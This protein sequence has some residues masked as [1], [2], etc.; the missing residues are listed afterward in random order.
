[1][2]NNYKKIVLLKGLEVINDYHFRIVKSLLSNDLKLNPKMK[3]EYDKIQIADLMEEKFPGDAGLGKLI[4]FFKEIPTLGDLA[5][6]L[7]REK[8]K[9]V[10]K[11]E[12]I[13]VKGTTPSKTRKQKEVDPATPASTTSNT[14]TAKGAEETLGLQKRRKPSKEE[15]GTKRSKMSKE[16]TQ[17]SCSAEASMS[18]AMGCSPPPQTSSSAPPNTSS[19]EVHSSWSPSDSFSSTQSSLKP[20]A[21][22][23]ATPSKNIFPK[24]PMIVMV[25][26]AT[27]IFKY[28]FSENEQRR[29]FH[30]TVATQTQF[31]HVK[32][33]N[34]NLKGKFIKKRI[35]IISNYSK[36]NSLLE[37]NE[38]SSVSE[39]GPDQMFEVPK[40]III[41]AKKTPKI[42]ILHKQTSGYIVYGL[43]MLHTK[44]VNRKTTI[45][46]IQDKTGSMTVVGKGECHD[47][48]CGKGDKLQLFCFRLRKR[49]NK[50]K[51]MSEMHSFIQIH[52]NTS[53][54][55][56][57]SRGMAL[58]QERSQHPKPSEA[59]TT[60]PESRPKTP[61][62]PPT[63]PSSSSFTKIQFPGSHASYL[64]NINYRDH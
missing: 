29:M 27:K 55:S 24:D 53:Q 23:Q 33:L 5:E 2:A 6:T 25:L 12:S 38:A 60:L 35:I 13:P 19:T 18:T 44:I 8:L 36:H 1:M 64:P 58:P 46:E 21:N 32:V 61:Q 50:S 62:M 39:A 15:T 45:Y 42:N 56:H 43:Y 16:Q 26:S 11:M 34:I 31:F 52:R 63:T 20:L 17:P 7:K 30:A 59:G 41:R 28:E 10:N 22:R 3:E 40:D 47:I 9:V 54:R 37:V 48:P 14:L 4:E 57:D 49:E 51:L